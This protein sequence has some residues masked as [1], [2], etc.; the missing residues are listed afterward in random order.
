MYKRQLP[1]G[2]AGPLY[3]WFRDTLFRFLHTDNGEGYTFRRACAD[4]AANFIANAT[5]YAP[6]KAWTRYESGADWR[7]ILLAGCLSLASSVL[8][9]P[10]YG[11]WMDKV[12]KRAGVKT[13]K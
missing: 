12:R 6:L 1:E 13:K 4:A 2:A 3:G 5:I 8:I 9:G 11:L 10:L 7:Q